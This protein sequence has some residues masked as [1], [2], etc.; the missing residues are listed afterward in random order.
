MGQIILSCDTNLSYQ[1]YFKETE[2]NFLWNL[3]YWGY[4]REQFCSNGIISQSKFT[5]NVSKYN[6]SKHTW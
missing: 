5:E 1:K 4:L 6:K 3:F 2:K